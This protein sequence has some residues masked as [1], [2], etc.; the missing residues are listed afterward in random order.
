MATLLTYYFNNPVS[1]AELL[2]DILKHIPTELIKSRKKDGLSLF[3]LKQAAERKGYKAYGVKLKNSSLLK[4]SVPIL[5]YLETEDYKHFA[6]LKGIKED[7]F[8]LADPR[9]GNIRISADRFIKEWKGKLA[10][11]L[12][13]KNYKPQKH[14]LSIAEKILLRPELKAVKITGF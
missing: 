1:E 10:L 11:V 13:K 8:F 12:Y 7:R 4:L 5:I 9:R 2:D 6:I 14:N 3:D